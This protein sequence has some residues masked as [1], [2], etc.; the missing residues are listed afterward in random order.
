MKRLMTLFLVSLAAAHIAKAAP[1]PLNFGTIRSVGSPN[2]NISKI[3]YKIETGPGDEE[4]R[5]PQHLTREQLKAAMDFLT[6]NGKNP[7]ENLSEDLLFRVAR[8]LMNTDIAF[9]RP[10]PAS[11]WEQRLAQMKEEF[12]KRNGRP[13]TLQFSAQQWEEAVDVMLGGFIKELGDPH[14]RYLDRKTAKRERED[15]GGHF[16]GIGAQ[17]IKVEEGI[18]ISIVFPSSPAEKAG[19]IDGD[20]ITAIDGVT[21]K[22]EEVQSVVGRL[23]GEAGTGV[24]VMVA[25]LKNP[26]KIKRGAIRT[27]DHFS[28]MAA[29]GIGYVFFSQ[30]NCQGNTSASC[31]DSRVFSSIDSLKSEGAVKLIIDLRG[32]G[33][34]L[35]SMA[36]SISSEFLKDG[37]VITV[38]KRQEMLASKAITDGLGRYADLPLAILVNG[39]SASA[40]EIVAAALQEHGRATIVGSTTTYGKGSFQ[41]HRP[42]VIPGGPS[43][44]FSKADGTVLN[45]TKGGWYTPK[46]ASVEGVYDPE[47]GRNLPGS[48]GVKPDELV[49][50]SAEEEKSAYRGIVKQLYGRPAGDVKDRVLERAIE[51]LNSRQ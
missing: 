22:G 13:E 40:S 25:R 41:E 4:P 28:K 48:G 17:I 35:L 14:T 9:K 37:D 43:G 15:D 29:P 19:L 46:G 10:I 47:I 44:Y 49:M 33:G 3:K 11:E 30:F 45:V 38:T 20:V 32:N 42:T 39:G 21:T 24:V 26:L 23:R 7:P 18:E 8:I 36:E 50:V 5:I 31:I 1:M 12:V 34:G 27:P 6:S 2:E 16:V 51:V